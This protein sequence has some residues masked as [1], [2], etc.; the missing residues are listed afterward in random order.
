MHGLCFGFCLFGIGV[1]LA[2]SRPHGGDSHY[3]RHD[4]TAEKY[5]ED[6]AE[7]H[8]WVWFDWLLL[9]YAY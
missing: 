2:Y 7:G 5:V 6:F 8:R 1:G 9:V 4:A 3:K